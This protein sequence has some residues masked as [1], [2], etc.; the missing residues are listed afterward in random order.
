MCSFVYRLHAL[1]PV[2]QVNPSNL[3]LLL[4]TDQML[5]MASY[6][7]YEPC[8]VDIREEEKVERS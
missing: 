5:K 6:M 4:N 1:Q 7:C 3:T 8:P 2:M